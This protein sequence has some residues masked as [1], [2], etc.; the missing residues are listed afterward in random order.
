VRPSDAD[1][2]RADR[3]AYEAAI[4]K[5]ARVDE[6]AL[7]AALLHVRMRLLPRGSYF[8]SAGQTAT[9]VAVVVKG[10]LREHF[11]M[12]DGVERTKAF[13]A[14]RE[15]TGSLADLIAGGPSRAFIVAEEPSRLLVIPY[16]TMRT[17]ARVFSERYKGLEARVAGK[18]IA[19]YLGITPVHLSRLRRRR[20]ARR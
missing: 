16:D 5:V 19:S 7:L 18:H 3:E 20:L 6:D 14:E 4:G 15:M 8:L 11:V 2:S 10:L 13:V 1:L 12:K 17:L 9:E